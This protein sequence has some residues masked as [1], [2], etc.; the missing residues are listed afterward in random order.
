MEHLIKTHNELVEKLNAYENVD[1]AQ[2]EEFESKLSAIK[3]ISQM[4]VTLKQLK[5]ENKTGLSR[6]NRKAQVL[7]ILNAD[8]VTI[9][10][11]SRTLGIT[12]RNVSSVLCYLRKDGHEIETAR[13]GGETYVTLK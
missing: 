1:Y 6:V 12:N 4:Q 11:I 5:E 13:I 8:T 3:I 2:A 9:S 10:N 7:E